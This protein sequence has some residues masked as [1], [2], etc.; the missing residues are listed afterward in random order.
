MKNEK[1]CPKCTSSEILRIPGIMH[2]RGSGNNIRRGSIFDENVLNI[3][4][5]RYVC[6]NC[7]FSEEWIDENRDIEKLSKWHEDKINSI[8]LDQL[9]TDDNNFSEAPPWNK[10]NLI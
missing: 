2:Y 9:E 4:V 3:L 6:R 8:D 10:K 5:T 7:G 1:V